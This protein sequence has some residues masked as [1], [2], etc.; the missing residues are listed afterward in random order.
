MRVETLIHFTISNAYEEMQNM[1]PDT[2]ESW[3]QE[4]KANSNV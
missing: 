3:S 1:D 2:F 4:V